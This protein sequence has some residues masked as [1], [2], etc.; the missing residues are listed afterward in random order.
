M[1]EIPFTVDK[2]DEQAWEDE[3]IAALESAT[4]DKCD[5]LDRKQLNSLAA[6]ARHINQSARERGRA[7]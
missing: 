7:C 2:D 1:G 4:S 3:W 6:R 5:K